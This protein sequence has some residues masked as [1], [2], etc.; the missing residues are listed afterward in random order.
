VLCF[1]QGV[2]WTLF[3]QPSQILD[4]ARSTLIPTFWQAGL[5]VNGPALVTGSNL[6]FFTLSSDLSV[7]SKSEE[8]LGFLLRF[9]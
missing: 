8:G 5:V 2:D 9:S 7:S 3:C 4:M 6:Y 1:K